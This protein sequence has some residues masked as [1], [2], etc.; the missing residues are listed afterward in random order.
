MH[1]RI[2]KWTAK[3]LPPDYL[4]GNAEQIRQ[5]RLVV[6][7]A[8]VVFLAGCIY[9]SVYLS[10]GIRLAAVG[11][12]Q[13]IFVVPFSVW[14]FR[15]TQSIVLAGNLIGLTC[16]IGVG[17]VVLSTGGVHSPGL[18]W[19]FFGPLIAM[20]T[21]GRTSGLVWY[22]IAVVTTIVFCALGDSPILPTSEISRAFDPIHDCIVALGLITVVTSA[23]WSF[24][25]TQETAAKKLR[26]ARDAAET[27]RNEAQMAHS[28]AMLVLNNVNDGLAMVSIDGI[29]VGE[30]SARF[31]GWFGKPESGW[32]L[33]KW[34]RAHNNVVGELLEINWEQLGSDWMPVELAIDQLPKRF[35]CD[36][37]FFDLNYRPVIVDQE[38]HHILV[39]C[40][41]VTA[42]LE[43]E[44]A[45][46]IQQEQMA[47][48]TRFV[49]DP[50]SVREF[51]SE[52]DRLVSRI[53][54]AEGTAAEE[55][56]WI[57]TLKGNCGIFGLHTFALWLHELEDALSDDEL[58]GCTESYRDAIASQWTAIH[59]RLGS[60]VDIERTDQVSVDRSVYESTI[61]EAE[62]GA[63]GPEI[64]HVLRRWQWDRINKT[65]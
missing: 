33:W 61:S 37:H 41:D 59:A 15:R 22:G 21:S 52:A 7:S 12:G 2:Q 38:L 30:P 51:L 39:I 49:R 16:T 31:C 19:L 35:S 62:A 20:M 47:I 13:A 36:G 54:S 65:A 46:K 64:A 32:T 29:F 11:P 5:G 48:F 18:P 50:R 1:P 28:N 27:A 9:L 34:L 17:F 44:Q 3:L 43:A 25:L 57:H 45:N 42:E 55:R 14:L 40:T 56:R 63:S 10:L 4:Q 58:S 23:A 60:I 26:A 53:T 6:Y 24:S 8:I